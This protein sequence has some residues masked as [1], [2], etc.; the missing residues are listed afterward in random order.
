MAVGS[1]GSGAF[2]PGVVLDTVKRVE[3]G[4]SVQEA[5]L[6][7]DRKVMVSRNPVAKNIT[8]PPLIMGENREAPR[9]GQVSG[10]EASRS[11]LSPERVAMHQSMTATR[12]VSYCGRKK[13][14]RN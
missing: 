5:R 11:G 8:S 12:W 13:I 6:V 7:R 4:R 9:C 10:K 2:R 1:L 3:E 14:P